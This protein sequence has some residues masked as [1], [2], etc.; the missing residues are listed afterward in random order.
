MVFFERTIRLTKSINN[1]KYG[2]YAPLSLTLNPSSLD[3]DGKIYDIEYIFDD[4]KIHQTYF[5]TTSTNLSYPFP[6]DL[7]D[8]R[9]Y[10]LNKKIYLPYNKTTHNFVVTANVHQIGYA[11]PTKITFNLN[12]SAPKMDGN[13]L[14]YFE[15]VHLASSRIFG[16]EN[17]ILY[18]FESK[19]PSYYI[20]FITNWENKPTPTPTPTPTKMYRPYKIYGPYEDQKLT[21]GYEH[22]N[23]INQQEIY[24]NYASYPNCKPNWISFNTPIPT[25]TPL[26]TPTRTPNPTPTRTPIPTATRTPT[27]TPTRTPFPTPIPTTTPTR[28]PIPTPSPTPTPTVTP[29][30]TPTAIVFLADYIVITYQFN[31]TNGL[32]LDSKTKLLD[33]IQSDIVGF[34]KSANAEP[35]LYWGGDNEG[36]GVESVFVDLKQFGPSDMVRINCAGVWYGT[37]NNGNMS[38]DIRAFLGGTMVLNGFGYQNVG[39]TQT[40]FTSFNGNISLQSSS[41]VDGQNVGI[42]AYNKATNQLTF[43]P[44]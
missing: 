43:T 1:L 44:A 23:F 7:G 17:H 41:C 24:D 27:P 8:P 11:L 9:N 28:T 4:E 35:Y 18:V 5:Y 19:N 14:P 38:I 32:D 13:I 33:P 36:T 15:K 31:S 39:G 20:P 3:V 40:N 30:P 42:V 22:I 12:L 34:C 25:Q 2:G 26:P 16:V 29:T 6:N 21:N 10:I 37:R